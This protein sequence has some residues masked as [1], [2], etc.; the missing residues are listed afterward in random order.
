MEL[1]KELLN[2]P[3]YQAWNDG[4]VTVTQ[5]SKYAAAYQTFMNRVPDY[6][7]RVIDGLDINH[8]QADELLDEESDHATLWSEWCNQLP[9]SDDVPA[10]NNLFDGLDEMSPS[11]LAGALH[12]YETQQPE[13]AETKRTGLKKHYG[14]SS[15]DNLDFFDEH[16]ENEEEHIAFGKKIR[17]EYADTEEF[18]RGFR[19]GAQLVYNSLDN[20]VEG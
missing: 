5:L 2:H 12:A 16:V 8:E 4:D 6:W 14:F 7:K 10:M 19:Q 3:F 17:N 13:V 15:D 18:D 1:P 11:A 20:F 9:E